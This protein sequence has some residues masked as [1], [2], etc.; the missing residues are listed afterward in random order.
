MTLQLFGISSPTIVGGA[1]S[2]IALLRHPVR[3][4]QYVSGQPEGLLPDGIVRRM[5]PSGQRFVGGDG[6]VSPEAVWTSS[7]SHDVAAYVFDSTRRFC[8]LAR[9]H[10]TI[11]HVVRRLNSNATARVSSLAS[12]AV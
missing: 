12:K 5:S 3:G 7:L 8:M 6:N 1:V 9:W 11:K 4:S 2:W 10:S